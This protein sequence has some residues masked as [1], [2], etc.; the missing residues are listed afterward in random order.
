MTF[1]DTEKKGF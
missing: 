1:L